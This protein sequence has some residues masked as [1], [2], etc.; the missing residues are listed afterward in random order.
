MPSRKRLGLATWAPGRLERRRYAA[1]QRLLPP[2]RGW[3]SPARAPQ[4]V[5]RSHRVRA[6]GGARR[7]RRPVV[8]SLAAGMWR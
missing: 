4:R 5:H 7:A 1:R 6:S 3:R 8:C 2:R